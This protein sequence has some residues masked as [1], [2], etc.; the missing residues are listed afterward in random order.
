AWMFQGDG[1]KLTREMFQQYN[2]VNFPMVNTGVQMGGWFRNEIKS[3][4]DFKGVKIRT[5]G[6]A[7][8]MMSRLGAL[9]QQ[10]PG[11]DIYPALDKSTLFAV[12]SVGPYDD[13]KL[14]IW[15]VAKYYYYPGWCEG[16]P[17]MSLYVNQTHYNDL[18]KSYQAVIE[19]ATR[20]ALVETLSRYD[21]W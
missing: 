17:Q 11:G 10:I 3:L 14:A 18:P 2:I 6:F 20:M 5:A 13:E 8:E 16:G 4:D 21:A 12:A 19:T 7:G 15:N 9:P 1:M